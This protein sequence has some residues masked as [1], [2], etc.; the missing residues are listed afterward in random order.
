MA[1]HTIYFVRHG[2]CRGNV[3]GETLTPDE[4]VITDFGRKQA[5]ALGEH[6]IGV[7][8][9]QAYASNYQRAIETAKE[10][11]KKCDK[12][13][14]T[15]LKMDSRIRERDLGD[16]VGLSTKEV[17]KKTIEQLAQGIKF[18][19][20]EIPGGE[21]S[22]E[23]VERQKSFF[24]ELF[25]TLKHSSKPETVLIVSHGL[26]M[27]R[28]LVGLNDGSFSEI[29]TVSNWNKK[30]ASVVENT[31]CTIFKVEF[32]STNDTGKPV[33]TFDKIH[34]KEHLDKLTKD[35]NNSDGTDGN[36]STFN[37]SKEEKM[38]FIQ[39]VLKI[40]GGAEELSGCVQV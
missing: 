9:T 36:K 29:C 2:Q 25:N 3:S 33:L 37:V 15:P 12:P 34:D 17:V 27:R 38:K 13:C 22:A 31:C 16:L 5:A 10:V 30:C 23:Y 39:E 11:L 6:L 1:Q 14:P 4:D 24:K 18:N 20:I 32:S 40:P 8:F 7:E 26:L 35:N 28:F 21:T 19:D